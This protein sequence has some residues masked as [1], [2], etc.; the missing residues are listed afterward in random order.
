MTNGEFQDVV[1]DVYDSQQQCEQAAIDQKVSGDCYPVEQI[2]RS[3]EVPAET[4]VK[5]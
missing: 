1:L 4:T 2:V 3:E 5:F